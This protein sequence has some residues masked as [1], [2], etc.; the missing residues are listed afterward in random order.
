MTLLTRRIVV[1]T[2][3]RAEFGLLD[4]VMRA[5]EAHNRLTLHVVVAGAHLLS[6][7]ETWCEVA[8]AHEIAACVAMQEDNRVGRFADAQAL[9]RGVTG[10]ADA[11]ARLLPDI[12]LVLGDRIEAFAA[13]SAASVGGIAV[14][15]IHGGDRAEGVADE[16]MRHAITK[17]AHIHLPATRQSA[18]RIRRM[19]EPAERVHLVGS[20]AIDGLDAMPALTDGEL[21]SLG[22]RA[23][24]RPL[25]VILHHPCGLSPEMERATAGAVFAAVRS[26][27]GADRMIVLAPNHDPGRADVLAGLGDVPIRL[28]LPRRAFIGLLRRVASSGGALVGNSSA[29]LIEAAAVRCASVTIGPRQRGRERG[30]NVVTA[31]ESGPASEAAIRVGIDQALRRNELTG[32]HP[33]GDGTAGIRIADILGAVDIGPDVVRKRCAY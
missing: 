28:G 13:A 20:P 24:G 26:V 22:L 2:G 23:D 10:F 14:A 31:A 3:T 33:Y 15:H 6:P 18:D 17:L 1:V 32:E 27:A 12:V 9:G 29:G 21:A 5:I 19:G 8:D 16:A 30:E 7:G 11:F 4:P 25:L